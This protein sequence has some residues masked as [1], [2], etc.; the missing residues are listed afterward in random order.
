MK[1]VG[2]D[3]AAEKHCVATVGEQGEVLVKA[4]TFT[5]DATGYEVLRG[6]LGAAPGTLVAMEATGHYW[7][8]L[9]AWL[10]T[11]GFAVALLNP[12]RTNRFAGEDLQRAKTDGLD[13]V[14]IARF[15]QQK[16]PKATQLPD[17]ASDELRELVRHRDRLVQ[18]L[19]DRVRQLHRL[20]DLGFPEF[21]SLVKDLDGPMATTL[22]STY[23]SARAFASVKPAKLAEL[24]YANRNVIG[25]ELATA[26]VTAAKR[27]VGAHHGAA[28]RIQVEHTCEDIDTF[29]HRIRSL[30]RDIERH[31]DTHEVGKLLTTIDG[32]GPQTAARIIAEVGDPARFEDAAALA[33]YVGVVPATNHSGK[34]TPSRAGL[35]PI[36]HAALRAKLWMPT[37]SAVRNNPWL[38]AFYQRLRAAGKLPKVALIAAMRK[39]LAAVYSVAK[40]RRAFVPQL[41][42]APEASR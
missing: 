38:R 15:A 17:A 10:V 1:F 36:G 13:A 5:E 40:H 35:T 31:L 7:K 42:A 39:L 12:L 21:T 9:F 3:V 2:I 25:D 14:S 26:L 28:Y 33:S 6:L 41:P 32:I 22:L 11:Q 19:G 8:N 4:T 34:R 18:D 20:V 37:L 30:E 27:S 16:R 23:P 24:N 29:R